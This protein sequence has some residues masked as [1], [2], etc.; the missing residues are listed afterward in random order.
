M[1]HFDSYIHTYPFPSSANEVAKVYHGS[2]WPVVYLIHNDREIYVGETTN[3]YV[4]YTQHADPHGPN[5]KDRKKLNSISIIFDDKFN[6]SAILDIEQGLIQLIGADNAIQRQNNAEKVFTLQNKNGGQS[7]SHDYYNRIIYQQK[8]EDIWK[9]LIKKGLAFNEFHNIRNSDLF[10]YSPYTSL[11]GEQEQVCRDILRDIMQKLLSGEKGT[12]LV[13]GSAG[14]GKSIL[15]IN[16]I[17]TLT[18]IGSKQYDYDPGAEE[19]DELDDRYKL[20]EELQLFLKEWKRRTGNKNLK[21]G[22]VVPMKPIRGAFKTVFA[23]TQGLVAKMVIG[24]NEVVTKN[25]DREYDVVFVDEAHRLKR[26]QSLGAEIGSFDK[27]CDKLGLDKYKA[28]CMDFL[29][30]KSKYQVL[31]YDENQTVKASDIP[32]EEFKQRLPDNLLSRELISQMR[33]KGGS[34][35]IDY[36]DSILSN[37]C[38]EVLDFGRNYDIKLFDDPNELI[39]FINKKDKSEGL[40]RTVAG[41]AWKWVSKKG[42][43]T[44]NTVSDMKRLGRKPDIVFGEKSYYWNID[45]SRWILNS[46]PEEIGCIHTTQGFDLNRVGVIFG[47]EIDFD[48]TSSMI[49]IDRRKFYDTKVK[50][51]VDDSSLRKFILN[52]YKV[53]MVRGIHGCYVYACNKNL[54]QYLS[55]YFPKAH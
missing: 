4:R 8:L 55:Q 45:N 42:N 6:K 3:A 29:F 22:F 43:G 38:T 9:Q 51:G 5:Y 1:A 27:C 20:R 36:V 24:P 41:Y 26:R 23:N 40:C 47:P 2:N 50:S 33:C 32:S 31:V 37:S 35:F 49:T 44:A 54:Q 14:T 52:A 21:I 28:N 30:M 34:L 53:M 19:V 17:L 11:T 15:L 13:K 39:S 18:C 7:S 16:M 25:N 12:A 10:K 48:P 46:S